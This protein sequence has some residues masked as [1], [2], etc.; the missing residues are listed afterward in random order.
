MLLQRKT[1]RLPPQTL[2]FVIGIA[3]NHAICEWERCSAFT[4]MS[5]NAI[6]VCE[7]WLTF[8]SHSFTFTDSQSD[9]SN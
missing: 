9:K 8:C 7:K 5:F 1:L 4:L 6:S 3:T 2:L